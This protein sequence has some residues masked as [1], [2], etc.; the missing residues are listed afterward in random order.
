MYVRPSKRFSSL[1]LYVCFVT[2]KSKGRLTMMSATPH[3]AWFHMRTC[4]VSNCARRRDSKVQ[5]KG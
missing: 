4:T 5:S 1:I 3:N 2:S